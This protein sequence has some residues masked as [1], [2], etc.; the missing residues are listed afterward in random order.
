MADFNSKQ[1]PLLLGVRIEEPANAAGRDGTPPIHGSPVASRLIA[2]RF[3]RP[4]A[5]FYRLVLL[6]HGIA[7]DPDLS[8][9]SKSARLAAL[10]SALEGREGAA[11]QDRSSDVP[12]ANLEAA[13]ALGRLCEE[14][15]NPALHAR[16]V[17]E[18][19]QL[20][21]V[22][23]RYRDWSE[24]LS[25]LSFKAAPAAR[26]MLELH[27]EARSGLAPAEALCMASHMV[28]LLNNCRGDYLERGR[29]YL[30]ESWFTG[31]DAETQAL[32]GTSAAPEL[33]A[34]FDQ[35]SAAIAGLLRTA[36]PVVRSIG[37]R[38]LRMEAALMLSRTERLAAKL[39]RR[40]PLRRPVTLSRLERLSAGLSG[41]IGGIL[42]R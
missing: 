23:D 24:L 29:V 12:A 32:G 22:K 14:G 6:A 41:A 40:D 7:G 13:R 9:G 15:A 4:I 11:P 37:N 1:A 25:Y 27:G 3:H 19:C 38:G 18:A 28:H 35:A 16:L 34:V 26:F 36:A 2:A 33:R 5:A 10:K 42:R 20:E 31:A 39:A 17:L 8:A 30:P 21:A